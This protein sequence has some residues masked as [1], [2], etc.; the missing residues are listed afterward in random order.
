MSQKITFKFGQWMVSLISNL[1]LDQ[2][3]A[4]LAAGEMVEITDY[5]LYNPDPATGDKRFYEAKPGK[6]GE[7]LLFQEPTRKIALPSTMKL[8]DGKDNPLQADTLNATD[9]MLIGYVLY[10]N[11]DEVTARDS[12]TKA[13][14]QGTVPVFRPDGSLMVGGRRYGV[15]YLITPDKN[16]MRG[17]VGYCWPLDDKQDPP[18]TQVCDLED[19]KFKRR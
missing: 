16:R 15:C 1:P 2:I 14:N 17:Q 4:K 8:V 6:Y 11:A 18:V 19:F 12:L 5:N 9:N 7:P 13:A 3:A 10:N